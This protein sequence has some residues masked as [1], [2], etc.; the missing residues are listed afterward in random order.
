MSEKSDLKVEKHKVISFSFSFL[1]EK[2]ELLEQ[3]DN[4]V[5]YVHGSDDRSFP[6][7]MTEAMEGASIGDTREIL[8]PPELGFGH[9]DINKTYR[10]KLEDVPVEYRQI[11]VEAVF[12]DDEGKPL[13]MKVISVENGEVFLD[14]N[15]PYAGKTLT[16]RMTIKAIRNA[17]IEEIGT[18]V[19]NKYQD[20]KPV[21]PSVH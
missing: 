9:Y 7:V 3:N 19:S 21:N 11:G 15:H 8:L 10:A 14:G 2:G 18:G 6:L 16:V 4:L 1:N 5:D 17:T 13:K 12:Q 20:S